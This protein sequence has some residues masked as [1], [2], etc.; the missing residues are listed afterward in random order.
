MDVSAQAGCFCC[1]ITDSIPE[2]DDANRALMAF[3]HATSSCAYILADKPLVGTGME[4]NVA[5]MTQVQ[6]IA[7]RW[8]W[9]S[10][11]M[12]HVWSS[13]ERRRNGCR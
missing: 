7:G 2:H 3:K 6:W 5:Y 12:L 11:L 9:E 1:C 13:C 8:S 10:V 4:A